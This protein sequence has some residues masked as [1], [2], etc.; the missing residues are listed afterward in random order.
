MPP[1]FLFSVLLVLFADVSACGTV[2]LPAAALPLV[3]ELEFGFDALGF[4]GF[5]GWS[6]VGC[7]LLGV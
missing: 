5:E 1:P 3:L 2:L 4:D 6:V 7:V